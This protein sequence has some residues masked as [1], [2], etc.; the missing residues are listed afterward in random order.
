MDRDKIE[1]KIKLRLLSIQQILYYQRIRQ[2]RFW[3]C[4]KKLQ[5]Y[6]DDL[7]DSLEKDKEDI[8]EKTEILQKKVYDLSK[9]LYQNVNPG[10]PENSE[11]KTGS[12]DSDDSKTVDA[13]YTVNK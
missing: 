9:K 11:P 10:N 7:K 12:D 13:D 3:R 4:Q 5:N 6:K 8:S 2:I 1:I